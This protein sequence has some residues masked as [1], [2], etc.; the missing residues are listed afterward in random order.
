MNI[1]TRR[2]SFVTHAAGVQQ[3]CDRDARDQEQR[4]HSPAVSATELSLLTAGQKD[5]KEAPATSLQ[6]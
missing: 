1:L 4:H 2:R 5:L 3:C 6:M